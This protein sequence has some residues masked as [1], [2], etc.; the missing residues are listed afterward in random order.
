MGRIRAE[1]RFVSSPG[2]QVF[3]C[4]HHLIRCWKGVRHLQCPVSIRCCSTGHLV[5]GAGHPDTAQCA[6]VSPPSAQYRISIHYWVF[7]PLVMIGGQSRL[8]EVIM[9]N[10]RCRR[11]SHRQRESML[12]FLSPTFGICKVRG[13]G[14]WEHCSYLRFITS[15]RM[16]GGGWGVSPCKQGR[17]WGDRPPGDHSAIEVPG[18]DKAAVCELGSPG[19]ETTPATGVRHPHN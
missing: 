3:Y 7:S 13:G 2:P 6:T 9:T 1:A 11:E 19:G 18:G 5:G 10:G 16:G 4:H 17:G 12:F 8:G 15:S 14:W